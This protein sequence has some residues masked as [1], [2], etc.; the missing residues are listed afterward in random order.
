MS[1][2]PAKLAVI[3]PAF[4]IPHARSGK[5]IDDSYVFLH[6][7]SVL[8]VERRGRGFA[9]AET[10]QIDDGAGAGD[11]VAV[12]DAL[13]A[14]LEADA[15]LAGHRLDRIV[16]ALVRVPDGDAHA[17]DAR[18]S[19]L[20]LK[21]ALLNEVHDAA[22][23]DHAGHQS[24]EGLAERYDLP[25]EWHRPNRPLDPGMLERELSAKAQCVWLAIAHA[26]LS[27]DEL[28]RALADHDQWR[29]A[30]SIA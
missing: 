11:D 2:Y 16:A 27:P 24:L 8:T 25:V 19:F 10:R 9:F 12:L 6:G 28:R 4:T 15:S 26:G 13:T 29:T 17:A 21:A 7:F 3:A 5:P 1:T 23:H 30:N 20:R 18:P 22:W 14:Q